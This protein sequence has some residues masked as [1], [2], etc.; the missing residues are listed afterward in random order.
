MNDK[1]IRRNL[2]RVL[3][4]TGVPRER[5]AADAS[6]ENDMLMDATDMTCFFFYLETKFNLALE[7][8][9]LPKI[10]SVQSTI[11]YLQQRCA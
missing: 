8:E 5:I 9:T 6:Y 1:M 4:K 10:D 3:R 2:Y 11:N 7:N